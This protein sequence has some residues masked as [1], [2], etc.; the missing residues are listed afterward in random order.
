MWI[1]ASHIFD[2]RHQIQLYRRILQQV[3]QIISREAELTEYQMVVFLHDCFSQAL[4]KTLKLTREEAG[5]RRI[6][7]KWKDYEKYVA[8]LPL[9]TKHRINPYGFFAFAVEQRRNRPRQARPA[10]S[11]KM[12]AA[13]QPATPAAPLTCLP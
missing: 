9:I 6:S 7:R 2:R 10:R 8:L 12:S 1:L 4:N 11:P 3:D 5:V 13:G